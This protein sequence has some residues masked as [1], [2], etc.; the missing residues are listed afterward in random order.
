MAVAQGVDGSDN[1]AI[2]ETGEL[3]AIWLK[4]DFVVSGQP[5]APDFVIDMMDF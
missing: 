5:C 3:A 1:L 4:I 2:L